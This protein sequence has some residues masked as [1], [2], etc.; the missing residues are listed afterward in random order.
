MHKFSLTCIHLDEK[1]YNYNYCDH[2]LSFP[3][4]TGHL[5]GF[6]EMEQDI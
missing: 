1:Y 3:L 6:G 2:S 4:L 5:T